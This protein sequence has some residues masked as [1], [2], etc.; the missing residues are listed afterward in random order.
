LAETVF[1]SAI[2]AYEA[3]FRQHGES[4]ASVM[5]PKGRQPLR[6]ESLTRFFDP[7]GGF[8]VLDYGCGLADLKPYLDERFADVRYYGADI[9]PAFVTSDRARYPDASFLLVTGA[10]EVADDYDYVVMSGVFNLRYECSADE[11]RT[12]VQD[13]LRHLF[14]RARRVLAVDFMT[15][16]VDYQATNSYHQN[17][18]EIYQFA[19]RELGRRVIVDHSYLPYEY[20]L[21][22]F[23]DSS[24]G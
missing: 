15:D 18:D 4:P 23:N 3:A 21:T 9:T 19:R 11:H 16:D 24:A 20:S 10:Q 1:Q 17:V 7:N 5:W 8:S 2:E 14:T 6:F 12:I 22:V 13:S